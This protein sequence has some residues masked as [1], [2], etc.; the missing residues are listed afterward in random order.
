MSLRCIALAFLL[1][2]TACASRPIVPTAPTGPKNVV[3]LIADG[4]GPAHVTMGRDFAGRPLMLDGVLTGTVRTF[5]SNSRV[6]DS[7]ASATAYSAGVKT[8]NG[9]IGVDSTGKAVATLLEAAEARGMATGLVATSRIT[10]ATPASF[11]AHVASRGSEEEIAAQMMTQ[12]VD[13]IFGGGHDYFVP[14]GAGGRRQ[15]AQDL[16]TAAVASGYTFVDSPDAL[17]RV[18]QVP[19][20][21]LFAGSHMDYEVDRDPARQPSLA[22]MTRKAL[23]LLGGNPNG[24]FLMVEGSR[25]DHAA[26]NNDPVGTVHDV[27]AYDE[28]VKVVLDFARANGNTL[29]VATSDHE[30]GGLTLGR[31]NIYAWRPEVLGQ[32]TAS[33]EAFLARV[34]GGESALEAFEAIATF[35]LTAEEEAEL[36]GAA[37]R[38]EAS[39]AYVDIVSRR[40]VV[41]WT[42]G[43]H[44]AVDVNLYAFGPGSAHFS[45]N[46]DNTEIARRIASLLRF[47]LDTLTPSIRVRFATQEGG[48]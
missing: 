15:D 18:A 28:A 11:A 46:L 23:D 16:V 6:T 12:N 27:L 35:E 8:Y 29:V 21:G 4:F 30:T 31:E 24:F 25:V 3:L 17:Q 44:T 32:V 34:Q 2:F 39:R 37:T 38:T 19:V 43:G 36:I 40:A 10:H 14:T 26:H 42:T 5:A 7:A 33:L 47:N 9:A 45:G 22:E 20:L 48:E 41:Q 1:T 13:V